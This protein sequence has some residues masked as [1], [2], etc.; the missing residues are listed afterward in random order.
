MFRNCHRR[1]IGDLLACLLCVY[2]LQSVASLKTHLI[3]YTP[4]FSCLFVNRLG[5]GCSIWHVLVPDDQSS[6]DAV[7]EAV[8]LLRSAG[9]IY[10]TLDSLWRAVV[11]AEVVLFFIYV[12]ARHVFI[13][14]GE[15]ATTFLAMVAPRRQP[16]PTMCSL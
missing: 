5:D 9:A 16:N 7:A 15:G 10:S 12:R 13:S 1:G 3:I 2:V 6:V 4:S 8:Q 11:T 14:T